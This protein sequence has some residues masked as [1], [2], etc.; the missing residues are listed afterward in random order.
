MTTRPPRYFLRFPVSR[1]VNRPLFAGVTSR[2]PMSRD[3]FNSNDKLG[4]RSDYQRSRS[5]STSEKNIVGPAAGSTS[6]SY[7][8]TD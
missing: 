3:S 2:L 1:F 4:A 8:T 6:N 5:K 7:E